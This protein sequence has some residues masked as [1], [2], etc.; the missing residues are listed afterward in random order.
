M[1]TIDSRVTHGTLTLGGS[2]F[3]AQPTAVR[4]VPPKAKAKSSDTTEVLD[5][6][7]LPPDSSDS[8]PYQ[9]EITAVQDFTAPTGLL[10][11]LYDNEGLVKPFIWKSSATGPT[12]TGEVVIVAGEIGGDV[13]K[14]LTGTITM[15]CQA[16]PV[17]T[18]A[19]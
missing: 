2:A 9:L 15:N 3:S 11:F 13:A 14:R 4:I 6:T 12:F 8:D 7:M 19:V 5:G 10:K 17:W 1:A 16:K 18:V